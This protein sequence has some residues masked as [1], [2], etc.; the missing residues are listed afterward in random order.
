MVVIGE[1]DRERTSYR[2]RPG[3]QSARRRRSPQRRCGFESPA[4]R[5]PAAGDLPAA[6]REPVRICGA[7][8]SRPAMRFTIATYN[9]HK[10][11]SHLKRRMV[12]H[13][14]RDRLR[15]LDAD[16]LFLQEVQ[17][18]HE[19]HAAPLPR[20]AGQAAARIHRRQGLA[21]G[22]LRQDRGLPARPSRQCGAVAVSDRR[23]REPGHLGAPVRKPRPAPLRDQARR[24]AGRCSTASTCISGCSSAAGSGRSARCAS[25]SAR[26]CRRDAPLIDRRRLQRLAAQG[27]PDAGRRARRRRGVRIVPRPHRRARFPR[28]CRCSGSTGS[29]RAASASSTPTSTTRF[30]AGRMSDHAALAATFETVKPGAMNRFLPGNRMTLLRSGSEFF[31]ALVAAID[32]ARA[33]GLARDLHLRRRRCR[34]HRQPRR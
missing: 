15:G 26:R 20:L 6:R 17:G 2:R 9:I 21:R 10:G 4:P 30:R 32:G 13:E 3:L 11:F 27:Q 25:G 7:F 12:I 31:P 23:A 29:T 18:V 24:R 33:R 28:C 5:V 8:P 16:I 19:R 14:L 22:R 34:P 1:R